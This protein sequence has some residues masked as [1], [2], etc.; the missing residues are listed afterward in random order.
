MILNRSGGFSRFTP[1]NGEILATN[2]K[3]FS[4]YL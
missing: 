1:Q 2:P 3:P 4:D